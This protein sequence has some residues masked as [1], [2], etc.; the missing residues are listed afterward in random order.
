[1]N[2]FNFFTVSPRIL[3]VQQCVVTGSTWAVSFINMQ[4]AKPRLNQFE[5]KTFLFFSRCMLM[6]FF[7]YDLTAVDQLLCATPLAER[8]RWD[9]KIAFRREKQLKS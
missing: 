9:S 2:R 5:K 7:A 3:P 4:E 1:M 8:F 6:F